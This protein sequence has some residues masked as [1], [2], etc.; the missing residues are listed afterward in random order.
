MSLTAPG[1]R[2]EELRVSEDPQEVSSHL[3]SLSYMSG[4]FKPHNDPEEMVPRLDNL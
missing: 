3:Q 4:K 2:K 1:E